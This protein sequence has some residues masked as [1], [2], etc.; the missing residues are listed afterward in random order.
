MLRVENISQDSVQHSTSDGISNKPLL[1]SFPQRYEQAYRLEMD[2][3]ISLIQDAS[4]PPYVTRRQTI[5]A[6]RIA[7]ACE[8]SYKEGRAVELTDTTT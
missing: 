8:L 3:F 5:L 7:E 2:H 6:S 4:I 1:F